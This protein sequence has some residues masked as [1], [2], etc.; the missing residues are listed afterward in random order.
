MLTKR[1]SVFSDLGYTTLVEH[2]IK[3]TD[4]IPFK[5]PIR[6]IPP[7]FYGEVRVQLKE[8]LDSGAIRESNS[9][10]SSNVV[11]V[12]KSDRRLSMCIDFRTLNKYF[13]N[14]WSLYSLCSGNS[15]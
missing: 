4:D 1:K 5:Q 8:L 9:L 3:L 11:L 12:R 14:N 6:R 15:Y 2:E 7:S 13:S 10:F